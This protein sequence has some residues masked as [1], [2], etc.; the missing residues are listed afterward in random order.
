LRLTTKDSSS[1]PWKNSDLEYIEEKID[2]S[3]E[4]QV[5]NGKLYASEW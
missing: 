2:D 5:E 1:S 3:A 4:V